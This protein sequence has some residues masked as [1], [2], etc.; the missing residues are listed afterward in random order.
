MARQRKNRRKKITE[1]KEKKSFDNYI[2]LCKLI[3]TIILGLFTALYPILNTIYKINYQSKCEKFYCIPGEYFNSNINNALLYLSCIVILVLISI[4]PA[5]MK[6][7]FEK[8]EDLTK[9]QLAEAA[10]ISVGIGME[11]GLFNVY[12]LDIIMKKTYKTNVIFY[13]INK[14]INNNVNFIVILVVVFGSLSIL[15][16]TLIDKIKCIQWNWIKNVVFIGLT[17]SLTTS[18][19]LMLYGTIFKLSISIENKT[20]YEFVTYDNDEYV[21]LSSYDEKLLIIPFEINE[22]GHYIF[23][24]DQ[25]L[26]SER[27]GGRYQYRDIKYSPK[28]N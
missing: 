20:K 16:I 6:K 15:G 26:F 11:M 2:V 13:S 10:V 14:W 25:Y 18:V 4:M 23:K 12:N 7:Y 21:I 24:T 22:N 27:Y 28:I 8:T 3:I 9:G 19:L 5:F 17:I 1:K